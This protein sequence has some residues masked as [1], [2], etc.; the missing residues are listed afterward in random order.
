MR[1]MGN[2]FLEI[3]KI[4]NSCNAIVIGGHTNP[5]GDAIGACLALAM[6]LEK[7]GKRVVVL[8]EPYSKKYDILKG[9]ELI[10]PP[11]A[12]ESIEPELFISLDCGDKERLG[13][14]MS[15][16]DKAEQ[17]ICIDHHK[18]NTLFAQVN[19]VE[20]AASSTSELI[21]RLIK[22]AMPI[23]Q[24]I[25][26]ALY[27]GI[28]YDSGGFRH[29]S[30]SATTMKCAGELMEYGI[31]F[32]AI[33]HRFFDSRTFSE[34]KIVGKALENAKRLFNG[35]FIYTMISNQEIEACSSTNKELDS[36]VNYIKGVEGAKVS[37]FLY[38]KE[39]NVIKASFRSEDGF[40]VCALSQ[41]FGGGGHM[42]AAGCSIEGTLE[43]ALQSIIKEMEAMAWFC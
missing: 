30:T 6:S 28:I 31:P 34:I 13:V 21:Y 8:L 5:D 4:I 20:E 1:Q 42:K 29:S 2:S 7:M 3:Q 38:E 25:A 11:D 41:K 22:D 17:T 27:A 12:Y 37:C 14:A 32:P 16:F 15:V 9:K 33:Y 35:R 23:N 40:D 19:Y 18:S 36:I 26:A 10:A 39:E 24:D 43:A